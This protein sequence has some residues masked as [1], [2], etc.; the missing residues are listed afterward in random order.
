MTGHASTRIGWA[1]TPCPLVAARLREFLDD[2]ALGV[3]QENQRRA[4][5]ALEHVNEHHGEIFAFARARMLGRWRRLERIFAAEAC[6][7]EED[8]LDCGNTPLF[9]LNAR[10]AP[11]PDTFSGEVRYQ[12]SPAYAWIELTDRRLYEGD[13]LAAMASVGVRGRGG[14]GYGAT[15]RFV[16]LELLMREQTFQ[17]MCE[18]LQTL[19]RVSRALISGRGGSATSPSPPTPPPL[20]VNNDTLGGLPSEGQR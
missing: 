3:P 19:V 13:A 16:R 11:S 7:D 12:A 6:V 15:E 20:A 5:A 9:K 14:V 4:T 18:K 10:D 1:L 8:D 17:V 2:V